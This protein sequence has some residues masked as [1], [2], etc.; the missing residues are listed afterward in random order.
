MVRRAGPFGPAATSIPRSSAERALRQLRHRLGR[1]PRQTSEV[2]WYAPPLIARPARKAVHLCRRADEPRASIGLRSNGQCR[3]IQSHNRHARCTCNV[4]R[5]AVAA[6]VERSAPEQRAQLRQVELSALHDRRPLVR[7]KARACVD[8][9]GRRSGGVRRSRCQDDAALRIGRRQPAD[10]L[11]ER[12]RR[13]APKRIAGTHMHHHNRM[14]GADAGV[15]EPARDGCRGLWISTAFP[16]HRPR[17]RAARCRA[18]AAH[19]TG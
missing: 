12:L 2:S 5:P 15:R 9:D 13:P 14:D 7:R 17:D 19:P 3:S 1:D 10:E 11:D 4:E 16:S 6:D 18:A 8:R